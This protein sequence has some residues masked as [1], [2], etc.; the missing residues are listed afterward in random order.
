M[1]KRLD[2]YKGKLTVSQIVEGINAAT[3]NAKRLASSAALLFKNEDYALAASISA[4]SIEESGKVPILRAM[5]VSRNEQ[6]LTEEWKRFRSHTNKNIQ[7]LI[8]ELFS[9]GA[10]RLDDF[11]SLFAEDAEH[12]YLLDQ[13][14]QIGFYTDCLGKAHWS[15]P[16]EIIDQKLA[17]TLVQTAEILANG[18]KITSTEIEL[19]IK[20]ISPV[21]KRSKEQM[22][23]GLVQWYKAMQDQGLAKAGTN[24][25]E[26]FILRGI[27]KTK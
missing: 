26:E 5:A 24:E 4:L 8:L 18:K 6:E 14:K 20:H 10:R 27:G 17:Q 9:K 12:P 25:M 1:K 21:W 7:W 3:A 19:W 23:H 2:Q 16:V 13:I 15:V 11:S 22:E